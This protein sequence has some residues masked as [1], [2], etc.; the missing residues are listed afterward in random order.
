M[1]WSLL[2]CF[3][4]EIKCL[5]GKLHQRQQKYCFSSRVSEATLGSFSGHFWGASA[6]RVVSC[7]SCSSCCSCCSCRSWCSCRSCCC[8]LLLSNPAVSETDLLI[9]QNAP[10]VS[11]P[12]KATAP[13]SACKSAPETAGSEG[14]CM[15]QVGGRGGSP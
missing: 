2:G 5:T 13:G 1:F 8:F 3:G 11:A 14:K 10:R 6:F 15:S 4:P 12:P 9:P 7:C